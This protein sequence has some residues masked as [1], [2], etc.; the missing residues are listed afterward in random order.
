MD[1]STAVPQARRCPGVAEANRRR[2]GERRTL[3]PAHLEGIRA[4]ALARRGVPNPRTAE[5]NRKRRTRL[6]RVWRDGRWRV[7]LAGRIQ[8]VCRKGHPKPAGR[9]QEVCRK[10]HPK[11][12]GRCPACR[13]AK[14]HARYVSQRAQWIINVREY[15]QNNPLIRRAS[16]AACR[17]RT[18]VRKANGAPIT[19]KHLALL[20]EAQ[21]G[22]CRYC[23]VP[24]GKD[25]HLDHR[26]PLSRGGPHEPANVCWS[27]PSCNLRKATKTETEFM[28][29]QAA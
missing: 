13:K 7:P 17:A 6:D 1:A 28:E 9:I 21:D 11:P 22:R 20:L 27:C 5:T 19:A 14:A 26:V 29:R 23:R 3:T 15:F 25:K 12:A 8:E 24:L 10:G 4:A 16:R 18:K 2:K